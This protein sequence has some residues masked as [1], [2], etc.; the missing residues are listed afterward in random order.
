MYV[1]INTIILISKDTRNYLAV[2][3]KNVN[4]KKGNKNNIYPKE[5][6]I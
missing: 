3:K 6:Q 2:K 5:K 1:E 4:S